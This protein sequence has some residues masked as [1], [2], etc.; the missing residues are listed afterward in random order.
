MMDFFQRVGTAC[1]YRGSWKTAVVSSSAQ[2]FKRRT[3]MP[4]GPVDFFVH[5]SEKVIESCVGQ[6]P[7]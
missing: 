3:E 7:A 6:P 1:K 2:V 5:T 4:S